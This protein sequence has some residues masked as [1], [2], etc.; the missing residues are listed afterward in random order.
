MK[1]QGEKSAGGEVSRKKKKKGF[2][3]RVSRWSGRKFR[4]AGRL[5]KKKGKKKRWKQREKAKE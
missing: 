2:P 1:D 5:K 4:K 3:E